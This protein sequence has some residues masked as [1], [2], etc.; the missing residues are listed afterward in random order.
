MPAYSATG[1]YTLSVLQRIEHF[2]GLVTYQ[3]PLL[4]EVGV[5]H[6]FSTRI[7]G[8]SEGPYATLNLAVLTKDAET[9]GNANVAANFRK[10]RAVLGLERR[11]RIAPRQVHAADVWHPPAGPIPPDQIPEAD[12]V[13]CQDPRQMPTVRTADCVPILLATPDG[14]TV[15]AVHAGWRGIIANIVATA[16]VKTSQ[17]AHASP[18]DLVAAIGPCISPKHFEVGPDVVEPF[19][20][21]GLHE[22]IDASYDKPHVDLQAAVR[23]Q[24]LT[25]GLLDSQ[26]DGHEL[27]TYAMEREFFSYRRDGER[28]GRMANVICC[29]G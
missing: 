4:K 25:I 23:R 28:T 11:M 14:K 21:A 8:V 6:G 27:C 29:L 18:S 12:A 13:V 19:Q 1:P 22:C 2:N 5:P 7:G 10:L 20:R 16:V 24:L 15:A 9:D 17:L 26:I 3:S